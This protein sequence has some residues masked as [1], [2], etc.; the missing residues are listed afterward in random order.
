M[1]VINAFSSCGVRLVGLPRPR[2]IFSL[3]T[4]T[5][6]FSVFSDVKNN[7]SYPGA[8]ILKRLLRES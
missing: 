6:L 3:G 1:A 2:L 5:L 4:G 7:S 8:N